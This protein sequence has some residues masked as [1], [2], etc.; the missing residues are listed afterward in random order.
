MNARTVF[1][2]VDAVVIDTVF[3]GQYLARTDDV[4]KIVD[5]AAPVILVAQ[6][7]AMP[8]HT[9][10][11]T[12]SPI[13]NS[14]QGIAKP[15]GPGR[16]VTSHP[17]I[18]PNTGSAVGA[19]STNSMP[20]GHMAADPNRKKAYGLGR[21]RDPGSHPRR[22]AVRRHCCTQRRQH[23]TKI[24]LAHLGGALAAM[25]IVGTGPA[26]AVDP[27]PGEQT[28]SQELDTLSG[29][30]NAIGLAPAEKPGQSRVTGR[31][32]HF[33]TGGEVSFM[34][35]QMSKAANLCKHGQEHESM[36][37]MDIVR[38]ILKL[39]EVQ[40]PASHDYSLPHS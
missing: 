26:R 32:G 12:H 5:R 1:L 15:T 38:A 23:M 10:A 27:L 16:N 30:W 29:Q 24:R 31:G 8:R 36:L 34:R 3:A 40:H 39:A 13:T 17:N 7:S 33:H 18:L 25:A 20:S 9:N 28:C 21:A 4:P 14:Q 37:R 6:M 22:P 35:Q 2:P 11:P 19:E